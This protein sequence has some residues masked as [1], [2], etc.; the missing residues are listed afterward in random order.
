MKTAVLALALVLFAP[1]ASARALAY[2]GGEGGFTP[3]AAAPAGR[4]V[5]L[6]APP[7]SITVLE[8]VRAP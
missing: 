3:A 1:V 5:E 2:A 7:S 8:V 4:G 6:A